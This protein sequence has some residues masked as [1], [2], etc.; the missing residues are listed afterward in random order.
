MDLKRLFERS[1]DD[2][3]PANGVRAAE[4]IDIKS[5]SAKERCF[6]KRHFVLGRLAGSVR[7]WLEAGRRVEVDDEWLLPEPDLRIL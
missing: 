7:P 3:E 2:K 4:E 1:S 6:K 5:L